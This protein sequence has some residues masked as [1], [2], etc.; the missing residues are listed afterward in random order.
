LTG[1]RVTRRY[2]VRRIDCDPLAPPPSRLIPGREIAALGHAGLIVSART[3]WAFANVDRG[4]PVR[5][6]AVVA[7]DFLENVEP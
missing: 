4:R 7:N 5:I 3:E 1:A 2:Q 6:P